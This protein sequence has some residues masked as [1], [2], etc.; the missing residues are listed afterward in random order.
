M[1]EES[2]DLSGGVSS[3]LFESSDSLNLV[4]D[5]NSKQ[6]LTVYFLVCPLDHLLE[7]RTSQ[8]GGGDIDIAQPHPGLVLVS[9][10]T[11][12]H[13][14]IQDYYSLS[15]HT[16]EV[17]FDHTA[18]YCSESTFSS[19]NPYKRKIVQFCCVFFFLIPASDFTILS[20]IFDSCYILLL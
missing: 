12:A 1:L 13:K 6:H 17:S 20:K 7:G 9:P 3:S 14:I 18:L 15:S 4:F 2:Q 10:D 8:E 5:K 16:L 11:T 19:T